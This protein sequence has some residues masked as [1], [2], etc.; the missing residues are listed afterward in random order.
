MTRL[1]GVAIEDISKFDI[2]DIVIDDSNGSITIKRGNAL[3][4]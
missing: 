4:E 1:R 2:V 3:E